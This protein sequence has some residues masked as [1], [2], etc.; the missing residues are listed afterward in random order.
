MALKIFGWISGVIAFLL[1]IAFLYVKNVSVIREPVVP[2]HTETDPLMHQPDSGLFIVGNNWFRKSESGLY[3]LYLEGK[4]FERGIANGKLTRSLVQFQEKAFLEQINDMIPSTTYLGFLKYFVGWFH[5]NLDEHIP[6]EFKQEIYGI[7]LSASHEYDEIASPYQRI[8]NY[9]AAHDIGHGLQNMALVGCTSFA[10]WN[11]ASE[12]GSLIIGRNFDFYVGDAFAEKKIV[13]FYNPE[14]GNRFMMVT[15][16]GMTGVLSGMNDQG[17]TVTINA[18]KSDI[19]FAAAMPVSLLAREILQYATTIREAFE[20]AG[21]RKMFVSESFL[22]GSAKDKRAAVIEKSPD[23]IALYESGKEYIISTNHFQS[24]TLGGTALNQEHMAN[25]AS[26]Y[27]YSRVDQLLLRQGKNTP[28]KAAGILRDRK[29]LNDKP[30]GLGNEKAINQLIAHHG[31]IFQPEK[32]LVWVSTAPWQLGKFVCYDLNKIFAREPLQNTEIY[33]LEKTI[34]A[35]TFLR[36]PLYKQALKYNAFRFPFQSREGLAPDSLIAWNPD[37]YQAY[38][39]AADLYRSKNDFHSAALLY[40]KALQK[41]VA[42]RHEREYIEEN[43]NLCKKK[44]R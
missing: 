13:A 36:S 16:G 6:D 32:N 40:E 23:D 2:A 3:E 21:K 43:L 4:P 33:E 37:S 5:R 31:I 11:N 24:E 29:G 41:E 28:Q 9:H 18:A 25:S 15:F 26:A 22:I 7:S 17:L 35:D 42:T 12:D 27:R 19:P 44:L 14:K 1:L 8:L 10:T 30:L 38:M 34:P 20:I 39:I